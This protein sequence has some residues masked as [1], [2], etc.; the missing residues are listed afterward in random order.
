MA[1]FD[2][3]ACPFCGPGS[4]GIF[5]KDNPRDLWRC[6]VCGTI[7]PR[8]RL[9]FEGC[10]E[11]LQSLDRRPRPLDPPVS[12]SDPLC[13]LIVRHISRRGLALD[14]GSATGG[15][16]AALDA[17]GFEAHGLEPQASARLSAGQRGTRTHPGFFPEQIPEAL[18]QRRFTLISILESI[19]YFHDLR[20]ALR[21]A[22]ALLEPSGYLLL[23]A[24]H[25]E[26]PVYADGQLSLFRRFGDHVQ[27]IPT[28][29]SL[30]HCLEASGFGIVHLRG[31]APIS[32]LLSRLRAGVLPWTE[33]GKADRL[34]I[35]A[36]RP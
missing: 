28:A 18:A 19:Y 8:P 29:A 10:A 20:R 16:C 4:A 15:F 1:S 33:P 11:A 6:G 2:A 26:S 3:D 21:M 9:G 34:V 7:F 14:V 36:R 31:L 13:R 23:K 12:A 24:H 35:L 5:R 32:G 25:A 17:L 27:G 30:R 22:Q